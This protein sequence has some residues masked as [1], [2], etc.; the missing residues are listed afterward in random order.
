[1]GSVLFCLLFNLVNLIGQLLP[2]PLILLKEEKIPL[3]ILLIG[4][5]VGFDLLE[6]LVVADYSKYMIKICLKIV[7]L[8]NNLSLFA[9]YLLDVSKA[10]GDYF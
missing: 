3:Q 6:K 5:H 9:V 1:M 10:F 7:Y 2:D 4:V 8:Y